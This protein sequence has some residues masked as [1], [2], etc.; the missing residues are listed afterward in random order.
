MKD[1]HICKKAILKT[2]IYSDLFNYPLNKDELWYFLKSDKKIAKK[3]FLQTLGNLPESMIKK[4][5]FYCLSG[6]ETIIIE[7]RLKKKINHDKYLLAKNA[8]RLLFFIPTVLLIGI[9][10]SVAL[11]NADDS[12]D[13]DLF[14]IS[15]KNRIWTTRLLCLLILQLM[16]LRRSRRSLIEKD[17]ICINMIIDERNLNFPESRHDLFTAHEIGQ[18]YP[19]FTRNNTYFAFI[20]ANNWAIK[21]MPNI[22]NKIKSHTQISKMDNPAYMIIFNPLFELLAKK[23]QLWQIVKNITSETVTDYMLAFHPFDH[24]ISIMK[25]FNEKSGRYGLR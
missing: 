20:N 23:L 5:G 1:A 16:G 13:I 19:L 8:A 2:L 3:T 21:L 10:G 15:K 9:S 14:L 4:K 11:N 6:K 24:R 25:Q 7:R 18:L 17:K 22:F 12:D